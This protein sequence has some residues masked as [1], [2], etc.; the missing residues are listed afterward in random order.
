MTTSPLH[1]TND[2]EL[3]HENCDYFWLRAFW[4]ANEAICFFDCASTRRHVCFKQTSLFTLRPS[5]REELTITMAGNP[6]R[7]SQVA[8]VSTAS[9]IGLRDWVDA[10]NNTRDFLPVSVGFFRIEKTH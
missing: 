5:P 2:S 10:K 7:A 9:P 8:F 1:C 6:F 4:E 3:Q